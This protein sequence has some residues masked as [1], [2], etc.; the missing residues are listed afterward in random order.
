MPEEVKQ[1]W[2]RKLRNPKLDILARQVL[3]KKIQ[4][5]CKKHLTCL[6]CGYVN[7]PVK[8]VGVIKIVHERYKGVTAKKEEMAR[9]F[10]EQ[11]EEALKFNKEIKPLLSKVQEDL[12]PV[13]VLRIFER[14]TSEDVELLDMDP[15]IGRPER[16]ILTHILVPPVPI[17]PSVNMDAQG[18][19]E[20][21]LT[22]KLTEI[23]NTN[24]AIATHIEKASM[25]MLMEGWD[26]L[27]LLCAV[28]INGDLPSSASLPSGFTQS[29]GFRG[30]SQRLK[31]KAGRFRGN[32]S[33]KRV[34]FSSRTVISPDP[35]LR[36]DQV[37]VPVLIAK[38]LTYPERVN[39][40]N[41]DRLRKSII[42][43][44]DIHPGAVYVILA[45]QVPVGSTSSTEVAKRFLK[46][47]DRNKIAADLKI[48]DIVERHIVDGD[49][50][51]FN[52]QPS[53]HRVSIMCHRAKIMPHR[54][55][56]F[57]ECV[58]TPY[59]ADFDG[60]EMN[61][62]VPQT[63]EARAEA[64]ELMNVIH[65]LITPRSGEPLIAATQ[66]FLSAAYLLTRKD[67]FFDKNEFAL[68]CSWAFDAEENIELP[69][70]AVIKPV[71]LWTGKQIFRVLIKPNRKSNIEIN[72]EIK[73]KSYSNDGLWMCA[74]DGYV[75]FRNS[76]LICGVLD[77]VSLGSG[78]KSNIFHA[79]MRDFSSEQAAITMTRLSKLTSRYLQNRGFSIGISDVSPSS[80]LSERKQ[81]V[82]N[83]GYGVCD[84]WIKQ[85]KEG[86]LELQPG[87]DLEQSLEVKLNAELSQIRDRCGDLCIERLPY[88]N[89]PLIM[90]LC[91]SKGSNINISQ[92]VA[93][94]G[95][96]TVNGRRVPN[97]FMDRALPHY[98]RNAKYPA[99]KGFVENSFYT[100]LTA[101][102]FFFHTMGGRE[103]LV[104]TAVKTAETGYMQR[105]LMKALEDLS[106]QYDN[107]VRNSSSGVVQFTYGEDGLDPSGME[108]KDKPID[109]GRVLNQVLATFPCSHEHPMLP[110]EIL[111]SFDKQ[112]SE[113][114]PNTSEFFKQE[115][116]DFIQSFNQ[117]LLEKRK[118]FGVPIT[119]DTT[120]K[121]V[122]K[123]V[124]SKEEKEKARYLIASKAVSMLTRLTSSQLARFI[125]V[126]YNK[127]IKAIV[128]PGTAVGA[129]G[130]QSIG[131]PC[132]Q[133]TLKTFHFAGVASMNVTLGVPRIKEIINAS[134]TL[135]TPVI[136]ASL[137]KDDDKK[138]ARI[139]KGRIEKTTLGEIAEYI[140]EVHSPT[141]SYL[142]IKL[143]LECINQ[144]QLE[145]TVESL[146]KAILQDKKLKLKDKNVIV[147]KGK[148]KVFPIDSTKDKMLNSLQLLKAGLRNVIVQ[149]IEKVNRAVISEAKSGKYV[150]YVE[151][152]ELAKVMTTPGVKGTH[153]KSN[154][155]LEVAKVLGIEAARKTIIDEI[156]ETM[157]AYGI[158]VD[159]R[160][161]MLLADVM[162]Y[163][164]FL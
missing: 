33:G 67:T 123:L 99:A 157:K 44:P 131:E 117:D 97:G 122:D 16:L 54:T 78:S 49:Y 89:T 59:N 21:D 150:L 156:K 128:E 73:S 116:K 31:G 58:C 138:V 20:D 88:T 106:I 143:D 120:R 74:K 85:Y 50:V 93:C 115:L 102:E 81:E 129:I 127:Y 124:E 134:K 22:M 94:V 2:L 69:P 18:S 80:S 70:P 147:T 42:N 15:T 107:T 35:N 158:N 90:S 121:D 155:I 64:A 36:I 66:D 12:N 95:Q 48:G 1:Q 26:F 8:K 82:V 136:T 45:S 60:D 47:G 52:R 148:I 62:H 3:F 112:L 151:G 163:R 76:D 56:R 98:E 105:R 135:A 119:L 84:K 23:I 25:N 24:N 100:G 53:L 27:Q 139:I 7:A 55:F 65:N 38:I 162:S 11:F 51:L 28:L 110:S 164:V 10:H 144:L 137:I 43:G 101:P 34:D 141:G 57:N 108:A 37:A 104:D 71:Q 32:L 29:K 14:I 46:Y 87:C 63:E 86:V 5:V 30:L 149:G 39:N 75:V 19:N 133:M 113:L 142:S 77:K 126:C 40:I 72:L 17:R 159:S 13:E 41:I 68:I 146:K 132:T 4:G 83:E 125:Q 91:G 161:I 130:A 118:L 160:H 96:Q 154:H 6:Y 92:M 145:L 111:I 140:K 153:T 9:V 103:G 152:T 61:L 114:A 109:Y 79:I